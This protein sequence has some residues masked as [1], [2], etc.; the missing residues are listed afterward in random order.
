MDDYFY[1]IFT[2]SIMGNNGGL[3]LCIIITHYYIRLVSM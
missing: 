3:L 1:I 2:R